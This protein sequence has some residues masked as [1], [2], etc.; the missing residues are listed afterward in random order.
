MLLREH[1]ER[2]ESGDVEGEVGGLAEGGGGDAD[3][4]WGEAFVAQLGG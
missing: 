1:L 3:G 4:V 2:R